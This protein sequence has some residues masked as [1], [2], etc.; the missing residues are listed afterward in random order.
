MRRINTIKGILAAAVVSVSLQCVAQ[1]VQEGAPMNVVCK[2]STLARNY[3]E[4]TA[5]MEIDLTDVK[6]KSNQAAIFTPMIVNAEDTLR[7]PGVGVY[8]RTRWYQFERNGMRPISGADEISMRAGN[9]Q[10]VVKYSQTV[11]YDSW[12]NG[13]TLI[14]QRTDYGCA[15]CEATVDYLP[16][17]L[18]NYRMVIY[19][20]ELIFQAAIAEEVKT[21][22]L[23]G[24]AYVDFPVN[25]T[26]IYPEYRR[27]SIEL[28]KI[29]ATIDSV[30]NDKDITVKSLSIKGFASPEGPYDNNIR[31]AKGRTEALRNYVQQLYMFP[32]GFIET[33]YEPEDWEGLREYVV[34]STMPG[35]EGILAIID[36][37]MAPDPKN[38][39][40]EK[41]YPEQ[42]KFLLETVYPALRHSDYRIEY[43]IRGF[44][45]ISEIAELM[46]THPSKLSL[47][48]MY[49]LAGTLVP[50]TPEYNEVM[51]TAVKM[52]PSDEVAI[53]NAATAAMQRDD[54]NQ[55]DRYLSKAGSSAD[56]LYARGV[57][58]GL[59]KEYAKAIWYMEQAEAKGHPSAAG[60]IEKLKLAKQYSK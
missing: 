50:G 56:A 52:Y 38:S 29:I 14:L 6:V 17:E 31:L 10:G 23:A 19:E 36:S 53:L 3:D 35:R 22:E 54:L 37:Y 4:I 32:Y 18:A 58:C 39:K 15:G 8:G 34:N 59:Q 20:P 30:R 11:E 7:L 60:E 25:L 45:D 2:K 40:L 43:T 46:R 41:D 16:E 44:N 27:N 51:E 12:M 13:S 49:M 28:G 24:R 57:L 1:Q 47:N 55:A 9:R 48:E 42:Y 5:K 33:S 26:T 21:R